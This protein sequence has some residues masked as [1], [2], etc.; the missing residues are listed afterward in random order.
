MSKEKKKSITKKEFAKFMQKVY[1]KYAKLN[2]SLKQAYTVFGLSTVAPYY[3]SDKKKVKVTLAGIGVFTV[4]VTTKG[5]NKVAKYYNSE[6]ITRVL[7][8]GLSLFD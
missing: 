7:N 3:L 4:R 6:T 1:A 8:K 5:G 2:C